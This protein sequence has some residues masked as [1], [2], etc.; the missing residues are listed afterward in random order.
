MS[1]ADFTTQELQNAANAMQLLLD[2]ELEH[3][4]AVHN[5]ILDE[6]GKR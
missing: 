5:K 4:Q 2:L 1:L 3:T 6:L